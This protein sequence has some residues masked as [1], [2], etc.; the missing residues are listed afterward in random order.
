MKKLLITIFCCSLWGNAHAEWEHF[1][2]SDRAV[3]YIDASTIQ[4][5]GDIVKI[6]VMG[7]MEVAITKSEIKYMSVK[8]HWELNCKEKESNIPFEL[9]YEEGMGQGERRIDRYPDVWDP[10][11]PDSISATI[12]KYACNNK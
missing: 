9:H 5:T 11:G 4:R 7:D 6:W 1:T 12:L 3:F 8:S 2:N 10:V